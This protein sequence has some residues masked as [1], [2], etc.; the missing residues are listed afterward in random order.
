MHSSKVISIAGRIGYRPTK[1]TT[2]RKLSHELQ[3]TRKKALRPMLISWLRRRKESAELVR[4]DADNFIS[5]FG[6]QAYYEAR[7]RARRDKATIDGNRP[8]G[9][10]TRV[11]LEIAKRQGIEIGHSGF[12]GRG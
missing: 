5:S 9:H 1:Q 6:D 11:K 4:E 3:A 7:D 2:L 8:P 10:W 12:D